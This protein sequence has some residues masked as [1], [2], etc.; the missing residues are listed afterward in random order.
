MA[1]L[2]S[3][4]VIDN[5][6][7][8]VEQGAGREKW[9][10]DNTETYLK[11][12]NMP[13]VVHQQ[14]EVS[15]GLFSQKRNFIVVTCNSLKDYRMYITARSFGADLDAAWYL[16]VEPRFLKRTISKYAAGNPQALAQN[17]DLFSQQDLGAFATISGHCLKRTLQM[18]LE[19]LKQDPSGLNTR[20]K[21]FL[22][23]W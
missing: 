1:T 11:S 23:V 16:T 13:G 14:E 9:V 19:E 15:T 17:I 5:W 4:T 12:A 20:S 22:S 2:R 7:M 3:G 6:S 21:G 8:I 18:L 10:L